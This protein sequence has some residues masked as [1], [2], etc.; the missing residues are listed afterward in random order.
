MRCAGARDLAPQPPGKGC[1]G[2]VPR[3]P[4]ALHPARL[5][6]VHCTNSQSG[7]GGLWGSQAPHM[8]LGRARGLW[9]REGPRRGGH[10]VPGWKHPSLLGAPRAWTGVRRGNKLSSLIHSLPQDQ[11]W[12]VSQNPCAWWSRRCQGRCRLPVPL[13]GEG[14]PQHPREKMLLGERMLLGEP[15]CAL[16]TPGAGAGPVHPGVVPDP[17][18]AAGVQRRCKPR[19]LGLGAG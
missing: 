13:G 5:G 14:A 10:G 6:Q 2:S 18:P 16:R 7:K 4:K 9:G 3:V 11:A 8:Q 19:D 12:P 1:P 15:R 17:L